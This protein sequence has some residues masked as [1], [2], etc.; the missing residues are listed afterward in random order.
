MDNSLYEELA[1][2]YAARLKKAE[3]NRP[4][5]NIPEGWER[6]FVITFDDGVLAEYQWRH[7][8][9]GIGFDVTQFGVY[10]N[11]IDPVDGSLEVYEDLAKAFLLFRADLEWI[12]NYFESN[13]E[14]DPGY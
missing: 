12:A 11:G 7:E 2:A 13:P 6:N 10:Q 9:Y 4:I 8:P 1:T 14:P 3:S 5:P